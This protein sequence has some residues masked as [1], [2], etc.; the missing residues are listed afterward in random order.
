MLAKSVFLAGSALAA[1]VNALA[2]EPGRL[3]CGTPE[4]TAEQ[5]Q[6][7]QAFAVVEAEQANGNSSSLLMA[8]PAIT[9]DVYFHVVASS[10]SVADGYVTDKQL[11]DQFAV[12]NSN[13]APHGISF[14]LKGTDRTV[15]SN[16]AVDRNELAMKKALRKGSYRALNLY[17]LKSLGGN[18]GYCY[19]PSSVRAGS[20]DFYLDGCS[21]LSTSVP[22][23]SQTNYNLGKTVTH[24]VGH[25][26]GLYH[27]FQG[28]C[29]G[30]GDYVDDTKNQASPSSGCPIGRN[31]CPNLPGVDPIHN[32]MDYS[33]DSC[34]EEFTAGQE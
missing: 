33:Y 29:N 26:F 31:S 30:A 13:F 1:F 27:T 20:D 9:V 12:L 8:G 16:W 3:G 6:L 17:F 7:S 10:T 19:F 14:V 23:G 4:P 34:Y 2:I 5:L 15:N 25:W 11:A 32:Y 28:G 22:G 18:L 24:E 21:I